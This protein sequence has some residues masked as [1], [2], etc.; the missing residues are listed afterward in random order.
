M[1]KKQYFLVV[2]VE[3]ANMI[4]DPLVYDLGFCITDRNGKIYAHESFIVSDVFHKEA[5]LMTSAYYANK[6]PL[7]YAGIKDKAFK[8][9]TF[10]EA[11]RKL[12]DTMKEWNVSEVYAYNARFDSSALN[13][14][15]RWLT[16]SKYRWFFPYGTK[17]YDI[18][19]MACQVICTQCRYIKFCMANNFITEKGHIKTSAETVYA[20]LQKDPNFC[21]AHTGLED[22]LIET[23][24]LAHCFRQHKK[25]DKKILWNCWQIPQKKFQEI[26]KKEEPEKV[27]VIEKKKRMSTI[28]KTA[29]KI[30]ENQGYKIKSQ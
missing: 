17:I 7:Y 10:Y 2:D 24:I 4:N 22:V 18:W 15:Q 8:V 5:E 13:K 29:L 23:Q 20:Y 28:E 11:R 6:I 19:H 16:K 30:L 25:I 14:T 9:V 21:E 1:S 3:T 12:L 26:K 27:I